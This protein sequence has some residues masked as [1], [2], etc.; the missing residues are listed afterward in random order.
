MHTSFLTLAAI[1]VTQSL[2]FEIR[3]S[4][5]IVYRILFHISS[6]YVSVY[7][8]DE[9]TGIEYHVKAGCVHL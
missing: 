9:V 6:T 3:I 2:Q 5:C 1:L 8:I 7:V 4:I